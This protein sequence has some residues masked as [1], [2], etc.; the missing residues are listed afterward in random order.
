MLRNFPNEV[1]LVSPLIA[2]A[3]QLL[4]VKPEVHS[5]VSSGITTS[6]ESS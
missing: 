4:N 5:L 1:N 2:D 3:T 6:V